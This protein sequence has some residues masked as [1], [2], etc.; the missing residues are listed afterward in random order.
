MRHY[1]LKVKDTPKLQKML[2][3]PGPARVFEKLRETL[4][5]KKGEFDLSF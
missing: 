4:R 1:N 5:N 3:T 2:R